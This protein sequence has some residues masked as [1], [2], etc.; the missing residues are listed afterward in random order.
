MAKLV[1]DIA[2]VADELGVVGG[3]WGVA[4][5]T[6]AH[7]RALI[8][9]MPGE[10]KEHPTAGVG[11]GLYIDS[12]DKAELLRQTAVQ[13]AQDGMSVDIVTALPNGNIRVEANY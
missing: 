5:S 6:A 13:L 1:Y 11:A 3:D 7:Q 8:I 2:S 9:D 12:E 10:D 4:E